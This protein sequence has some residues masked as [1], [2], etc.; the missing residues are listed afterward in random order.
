[1]LDEVLSTGM[2]GKLAAFCLPTL[3]GHCAVAR[4]PMYDLQ[5]KAIDKIADT[6]F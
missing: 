2:T 1:M 4:N 5:P 3:F 6:C